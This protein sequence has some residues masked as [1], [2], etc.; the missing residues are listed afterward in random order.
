MMPFEKLDAWQCCHE[1]FSRDLPSHLPLPEARTLRIDLTNASR[2]VLGRRKHC[3]GFRQ[4]GPQGVSSVL[5]YSFGVARRNRLCDSSRDG[6]GTP[7]HRGIRA[8]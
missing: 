4:T 1:L 8:I 7:D 3:R 6:P 2:R 5:G